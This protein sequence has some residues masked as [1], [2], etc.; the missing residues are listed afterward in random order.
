MKASTNEAFLSNNRKGRSVCRRDP[1]E[2]TCLDPGFGSG[3]IMFCA[4]GPSWGPSGTPPLP[5][6]ST[7]Q[8]RVADTAPDGAQRTGSHSTD[9]HESARIRRDAAFMKGEGGYRTRSILSLRPLSRPGPQ[10]TRTPRREWDQGPPLLLTARRASPHAPWLVTGCRGSSPC[11]P[12]SCS[13]HRNSR[14]P[15]HRTRRCTPGTARAA[16]RTRRSTRSGGTAGTGWC[17][18]PRST[19]RTA[20]AGRPR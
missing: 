17:A 18:P 3:K 10:T 2:K 15:R 7:S 16:A 19:R 4:R 6:L 20:P 14:G 1:P 9:L 5:L 8:R 11:P 12:R 13:S